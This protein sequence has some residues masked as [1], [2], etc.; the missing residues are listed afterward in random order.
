MVDKD[1]MAR[2]PVVRFVKTTALTMQEGRQLERVGR[3]GTTCVN[4]RA[5]KPPARAAKTGGA[6]SKAARSAVQSLRLA[7]QWLHGLPN[8]ITPMWDVTGLV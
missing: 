2:L 3:P 8:P 6:N 7:S 4:R 1:D 5:A